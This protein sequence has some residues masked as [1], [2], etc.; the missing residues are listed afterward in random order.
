MFPKQYL[1]TDINQIQP[2]INKLT[3]V[4]AFDY[5]FIMSTFIHLPQ[6]LNNPHSINLQKNK[7]K[8]CDFPCVRTKDNYLQ[9]IILYS[10][11][12]SVDF[13][14][15]SLFLCVFFLLMD[16][17][18]LYSLAHTPVFLGLYVFDLHNIL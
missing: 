12:Y 9:K 17:S 14:S 10:Y 4:P 8:L 15:V 18:H 16:G 5:F 2:H 1:I 6:F 3:S 11:V 13:N 7:H